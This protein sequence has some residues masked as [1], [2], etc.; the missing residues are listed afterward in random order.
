MSVYSVSNK[1]LD[2]YDPFWICRLLSLKVGAAAILLF[3]CNAF[4]MAPQ[5]PTVYILTTAIGT[6]ATEVMPAPTKAKKIINFFVIVFLLATS[7]MIFGLYSYF[8]LSLFLI[9]LAFTY[10]TLRFMVANPKV[11]ALPTVMIVWGVMNLGGGP[12]DLNQVANNYLYF[13]EFGMMGAITIL[14]FPDFSTNVFNSAFIRILEADID[15]IGGSYYKNSN[16][17]VL[18]ALFMIHSKLTTLPGGYSELYGAIIHFQ[19]EFMKPHG[20]NV[21]DRLLSRSILSELIVAVNSGQTFSLDTPNAKMISQ[22]NPVVFNILAK[23]VCSYNQCK[24]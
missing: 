1:Y 22:S 5:S 16:P 19:N 15:S 7:T 23:L 4:F 3:L 2:A 11:A 8:K 21:K 24:A 20:L 12:T 14:L 6:L 10:L 13:F 17:R 18:S 9:V